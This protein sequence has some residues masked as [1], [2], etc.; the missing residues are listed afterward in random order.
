MRI[1]TDGDYAYRKDVIED[2]ADFWG[3]NK[4]DAIVK[5]CDLAGRLVPQL[6]EALQEADIRPSEA[7]KI[8]RS[9]SKPA[10]SFIRH[11]DCGVSFCQTYRSN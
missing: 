2:A 3:V 10:S 7:E 4:T 1:R 5:S 6:E 11:P 9:A 8:T